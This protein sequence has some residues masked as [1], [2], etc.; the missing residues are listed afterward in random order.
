[1]LLVMMCSWIL[2]HRLVSETINLQKKFP[3]EQIL[4]RAIQCIYGH[5]L[6]NRNAYLNA[7]L[8]R[9]QGTENK[10]FDLSARSVSKKQMHCLR[11]Q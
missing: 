9:T 3:L 8:S 6:V 11:V 7:Y 10:C 2:Q 5:L 4:R 1:M